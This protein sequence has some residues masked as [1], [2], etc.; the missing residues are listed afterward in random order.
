M[1]E[2]YIGVNERNFGEVSGKIASDLTKE[3]IKGETD[4]II[5]VYNYFKSAISQVITFER[6]LPIEPEDKNEGGDSESVDYLYEPT[7]RDVLKYVL[8]KY[9]EVRVERAI[10]ETVTSEHAARMAAME[11]ATRNA[12]DVIRR[13]TLLFNKTRQATITKELMDIVNGTEALRKGGMD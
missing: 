8:P 5:L 10:L 11:N 13:L 2:S 12:S 9:I 1:R 6:L 4:E 7:R 3:F